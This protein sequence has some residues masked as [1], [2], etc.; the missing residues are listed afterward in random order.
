MG[1]LGGTL[2]PPREHY[3]RVYPD[4]MATLRFALLLVTGILAVTLHLSML[5]GKVEPCRNCSMS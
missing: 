5:R 3:P 1:T 4:D 2:Q